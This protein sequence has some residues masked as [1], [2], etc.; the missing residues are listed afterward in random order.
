M[1]GV[2]GGLASAVAIGAAGS[3]LYKSDAFPR[4]LSTQAGYQVI[5]LLVTLAIAIG[6]GVVTGFILKR[7]VHNVERPYRDDEFFTTQQLFMAK[8]GIGAKGVV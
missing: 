3:D 4:D 7:C 6:G 1:P 2:L 5:G 8:L